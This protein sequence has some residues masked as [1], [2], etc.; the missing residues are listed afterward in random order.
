[1]LYFL[2][3]IEWNF[4]RKMVEYAKFNGMKFI[5]AY[6]D[7]RVFFKRTSERKKNTKKNNKIVHKSKK[8]DSYVTKK[9][10]L[11]IISSD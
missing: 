2:T 5:L 7:L 1:M 4:S 11:C 6:K 10:N 9:N 3:V 8:T